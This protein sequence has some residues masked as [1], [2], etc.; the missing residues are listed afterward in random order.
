MVYPQLTLVGAG[1]GDPELITL[2]GI[3]ALQAADVVLYDALANENLLEYVKPGTPLVFV[4]KR[5]GSCAFSQKEI[6]QLIIENAYKYGHVVRLK[7]GDPFI[8]GR[9][10]EELEF[11]KA[12]DI[13]V[14]IVPGISSAIAVPEMQQIPLTTRGISE[15][16]WVTTGTT[17]DGSISKDI[18][19][20]AKS[21]ATV[22]VLMAMSK[23][24]E[25]MQI[26]DSEGRSQTPVAIIQHGTTANEKFVLGTVDTIAAIT[27]KE[28]IDNPAIIVIGEVVSLHP[29]LVA[30][31][32]E[33]NVKTN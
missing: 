10:H 2:K 33:K 4:G 23:L 11:A 21:T 29:S 6:N 22:V 24:E 20:A 3:K 9:G 14:A 30:E 18:A 32:V 1:P 13:P 31:F 16:F 28:G 15:S 8:F 19:L 26:F 12:F 27:R 7:G 25:I 5:R 17:K